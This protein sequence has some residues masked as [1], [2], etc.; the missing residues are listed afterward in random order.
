[1]DH[2]E[3]LAVHDELFRNL[4]SLHLKMDARKDVFHVILD[5][6]VDAKTTW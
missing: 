4:T 5:R 3:H 6:V 1:M 2:D